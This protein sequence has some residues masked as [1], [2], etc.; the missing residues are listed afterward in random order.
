[1]PDASDDIETDSTGEDREVDPELIALAEERD[2]GSALQPILYVS[3]IVLGIWIIGDF[4][5][6]IEYYF[7]STEPID[8]G[9][10]TKMSDEDI[11]ELPHNR[12]VHLEGI[13][14]RR[15]QGKTYRYFRF[16]GAPIYAAVPRENPDESIEEQLDDEPKG[17]VDRTYFD[18]EGRLVAFEKS[19]N[20]YSGLKNYYR[21][22]YGTRFC[23]VLSDQQQ[24]QLEERR[25]RLVVDN[26]RERYEEAS[27]EERSEKGLTRKPTEEELEEILEDRSICTR[28]YLFRAGVPPG[29]HWWYLLIVGLFGGFVLVN[30]YW[31]GRWAY[32]FV[33]TDVDLEGIEK[34]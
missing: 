26:W 25:R 3:V 7:S 17:S 16:V 11:A 1:M 33:G 19:P 13:P 31:L 4:Q 15:S 8:L 18:G 21:K 24:R 10:A 28:G 30:I 2:R 9:A 27:P 12:Y 22:Q 6:E 29:D 23:E 14:K 32:D 34:G 5:T 20:R